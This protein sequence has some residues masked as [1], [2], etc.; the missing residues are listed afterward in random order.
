MT[1]ATKNLITV[2]ENRTVGLLHA[3]L[4]QSSVTRAQYEQI[5]KSSENE[6][7]FYANI[8][9][10]LRVA[11]K[12]TTFASQFARTLASTFNEIFRA[13][14]IRGLARS[15]K[16]DF[17]N[18]GS[19]VR[20]VV[21][22]RV[23]ISFV[24]DL[25]LDRLQVRKGGVWRDQ[26][27]NLADDLCVQN[28]S[29]IGELPHLRS[30]S[31][32]AQSSSESLLLRSADFVEMTLV[33]TLRSFVDHRLVARTMKLSPKAKRKSR[34]PSEHNWLTL[35][36]IPAAFAAYYSWILALAY[37]LRNSSE[38]RMDGIGRFQLTSTGITGLQVAFEPDDNLIQLLQANIPPEGASGGSS[39]ESFRNEKK[40]SHPV[41]RV[42]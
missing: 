31:R 32:Q 6:G 42:A 5:L 17:S 40:P 28:A 13:E 14:I 20:D 34:L 39:G 12:D 23:R 19:F 10:I 9:P 29:I 15:S 25:V 16:L 27:H 1:P 7:L 24:S 18:F 37:E 36:S 8:G 35:V 38:F 4:A 21:T 30:Y 3:S 26:L 33:P 11:I 41:R 2:M 22:A